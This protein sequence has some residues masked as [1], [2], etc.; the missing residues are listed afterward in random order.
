M[1][2]LRE[3]LDMVI[4]PTG[5]ILVEGGMKNHSDETTGV[6]KAESYDPSNGTWRV[7]PE[8]GV[9]RNYHS[10]ALLMPDGAVWVAG[11][12]FACQSG[13]GNRELRIEIFRPWYW[14]WDRPTITE[15]RK[16]VCLG[17]RFE[18]QTPDA[19]R[20]NRVAIVRCGSCTHNFNPDQRYVGLN[21]A[22]NKG[23]FLEVRLPTDSRVAI[24]GYY[25]LF[26]IDEDGVPSKGE[27]LRVCKRRFIV[28]WDHWWRDRLRLVLGPIGVL[29]ESNL[30][31][32]R[33]EIDSISRK[34]PPEPKSRLWQ[35]V[36]HLAHP[37]AMRRG[38]GDDG[39]D[40]DVK[41]KK[42]TAKSARGD[43]KRRTTR[44][45]R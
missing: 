45:D 39:G 5:E 40:E 42:S 22:V 26:I 11:S 7:L 34:G 16:S 33:L 28:D 21:F 18:I 35:V 4:L 3:N 17:D 36:D 15:T 44:Q 19:D 43:K 29:D 12:N 37:H 31:K 32:I 13:L 10:V 38:G 23:G 25:L 1:N 27:F 14:C 8:A 6:R 20:I 2:P 24:P 9:N 41:R 30:E